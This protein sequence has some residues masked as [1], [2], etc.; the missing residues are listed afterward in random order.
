MG[1]NDCL[2]NEEVWS[3]IGAP[4]QEN[5]LMMWGEP[6][7]TIADPVFR[8]KMPLFDGTLASAGLSKPPNMSGSLGKPTLQYNGA[9]ITY[10]PRRRDGVTFT[11][12]W[13]N[14]KM[15]LHDG[16]SPQ[17][18]HSDLMAQNHIIYRQDSS[19]PEE[20]QSHSSSM[21]HNP[22]KPSFMMYAK[23][24]EISSP[25][26]AVPVG[27]RKPKSGCENSSS[28]S[29][30]SVYLAIPKPVYRRSHCCNELGCVMGPQYCVEQGS[31]RIPNTVYERE[32]SQ[33][34]ARYSET[35]PIQRKT[36]D[37][38]LQQKAL[39]F[40][41]STDPLKRIAVEAYSPSRARTLPAIIEPNYSSYSCTPPRTIFR[42][43]SEPGQPFQTP[44]R[45]YNG[46]YP[47]HPTYE[48]MTSE[49][50]QERSP[51]SKYGQLAQH[52]VFYYPQANV[53]VENRTQRKDNGSKQREDVP[54]IHKCQNPKPQEHYIVPQSLRGEIPLPLYST[55]MLPAHSFIQGFDY[56]CYA[57]QRF[58][59]H[60]GQL[61]S[62]LRRQHL[63]PSFHP[64]RINVSPSSQHK[65]LPLPSLTSPQKDRPGTGL[66]NTSSPFLRM[67][68]SSPTRRLSQPGISPPSI[69][70]SHF[71]PPHIGLPLNPAIP[72]P[73]GMNMNRPVDYSCE[74][75]VACL[76][77]P[78]SLPGS[79]AA[80]LSQSPHHSSERIHKAMAD[81]KT[82]YSPVV[83][84]GSKHDASVLS[85]GIHKRCLKRSSS[86]LSPPIKMKQE[87][88]DLYKVEP[89]K[90]QQKMEC[91][92]EES[93]TNSPPMPVI[94]TVFSLASYQAYLQATRRFVPSRVPQQI[95]RPSEQRE[96]K[97]M[98]D[99]KEKRPDR[100]EEQ[101]VASKEICPTETAELLEPKNIKVE[102][103]DPSE[104]GYSVETHVGHCDYMKVIIKKEPEETDSSD[105]GPMLLTKKCELNELETK[106]SFVGESETSDNPK[107]GILTTQVNS[108]SQG[109]AQ[110][111]LQPKPV[112]PTLLPET[113]LDF[114]NIPPH[115]LKLS[116][117]NMIIPDGRH[118]S[119]V[120]TPE[121]PPSPPTA[122]IPKLDNVPLRQHFLE[123]HNSLCQLVSK[124]VSATSEQE[125]KDWLSKL[126]IT[127]PASPTTKGQ[128]VTRLLGEEA[129][130]VWVNQEMNSALHGVLQRVREYTAQ[131]RCPFPHVFRAGAVFLPMLVVKELLFPMVQGCFIDQVLQE[132]KVELR[133]TTLSE[134][135][136]LVQLHKR[137]F[138]SKLRRLMSLKHLPCIYADVVNLLY[139]TYVCQHL[140]ST[141]PDVQKKAQD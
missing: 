79:P 9:Y 46:L 85:S 131:K 3:H 73:A 82:M 50:Y 58:H 136:I 53:E 62:P 75:Q 66:R 41:A 14:S 25:T 31:P 116:S 69:Q 26:A 97:P 34:E 130:A 5:N 78:K 67:D 103:V 141:S 135:K 55:E 65:D 95:I 56:P 36:Q 33:S 99:I 72:P 35:P 51:M 125:L 90:K 129:R 109:N 106:P 133:P 38:L 124:S 107:T 98:P 88:K 22:P 11:P 52:P 113:K 43:L 80:W 68:Q 112:S 42:S 57:V 10:D 71:F 20:D 100:D 49:V 121:R 87:N 89:A 2:H 74:A 120:P 127:E 45:G 1:F 126:E 134:E 13:S 24:P 7:Q 63:S 105:N 128:K 93:Q 16:K 59:L 94:D 77:L 15:T 37:S 21:R 108:S 81:R 114:K 92:K 70:M 138:S 102:K 61:R 4:F 18:H 44:P 17:H 132:H 110:P 32:W 140:E 123:L 23:S 137:A 86:H 118:P 122:T 91:V 83:A 64:S 39:Q 104:S 12:P 28:Y 30:N 117:Y 96:V 29:D 60:E 139:Y 48:H 19:S 115:C 101:P 6:M 40:Q 47:S 8:S 27:M 76:N 54:V 84:T 119:H 111:V